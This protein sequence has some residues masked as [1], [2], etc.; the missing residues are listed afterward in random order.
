MKKP[1]LPAAQLRLIDSLVRHFVDNQPSFNGLL[2][3]LRSHVEVSRRLKDLA[4][5]V[6]WRVKDPAH[7]RAKLI[8][9]GLEARAQ[10]IGFL[11]TQENLFETINDLAGFRILHLH[12]RQIEEINKELLTIFDEQQWLKL[13]GPKARTWDDE[14]RKYFNSIGIETQKSPSMYTSVHYVVQPNS[15]TKLTC[16]IQVRTLM[17]EV[18]G[19]VDHQINYPVKTNSFSCEEQIKVLARVTSSCSRLVDSIFL[20]YQEGMP[21]QALLSV[22][23]KKQ[24]IGAKPE[25]KIRDY[26]GNVSERYPGRP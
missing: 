14:S 26:P 11:Y 16:E 18:W 24:A 17:E 23:R 5:S 12:T 4:H 22:A 9:K 21:V 1:E 15:R 19:E 7:L 20:T 8:R 2:N 25:T 10:G 6:K 3:Q 13:E